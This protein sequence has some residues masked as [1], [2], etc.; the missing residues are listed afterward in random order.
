MAP[1]IGS[2]EVFNN[3]WLHAIGAGFEQEDPQY[4]HQWLFDWLN[5]GWLA[6]A[7]VEGFLDAPRNG[8]YHIENI[9]LHGKPSEIVDINSLESVIIATLTKDVWLEDEIIERYDLTRDKPFA[10]AV[11]DLA[12]AKISEF[13]RDI[14][15]DKARIR[16]QVEHC[17]NLVLSHGYLEESQLRE[18]KLVVSD[19]FFIEF[20]EDEMGYVGINALGAYNPEED[21]TY[22]DRNKPNVLIAH[23]TGHAM[24]SDEEFDTTGFKKTGFVMYKTGDE[25][26]G[27]QVGNQYFNEGATE[28]WEEFSVNDGSVTDDT[29]MRV[30]T[31]WKN[32]I[33]AILEQTNQ[34]TDDLFK[35]YFA[36][37]EALTDFKRKLF[38]KY[39]TTIDG[40]ECLNILISRDQLELGPD[41][42]K[43]KQV[44]LVYGKKRDNR[45]INIRRA[46][47]VA[48]VFS[49]VTLE[50]WPQAA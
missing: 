19:G 33:K 38:D 48:E 47:E 32:L 43:G 8:A 27:E 25:D 10:E 4:T 29:S 16:K 12:A 50:G 3:A 42:L 36:G 7:A 24:S 46:Y 41:I 9:V 37:G 11:K 34:S 2:Q 28:I 17:R 15:A 1:V 31:F 39:N 30:Y 45:P 5:S 6:Q 18:I 20:M 40:L 13:K 21:I 35:A 23:E 44:T 22:V 49:N 26:I 14:E